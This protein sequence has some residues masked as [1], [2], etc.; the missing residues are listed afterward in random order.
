MVCGAA[1]SGDKG[2][3]RVDRGRLRAAPGASDRDPEM[4]AR[5]WQ[6]EGAARAAWSAVLARAEELL[7]AGRR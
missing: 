6:G 4:N 5:R 3:F 2:T 7:L 1:L